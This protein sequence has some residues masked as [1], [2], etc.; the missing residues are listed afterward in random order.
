MGECNVDCIGWNYGNEGNVRQR[1]RKYYA[2]LRLERMVFISFVTNAF[3][4]FFVLF[5]LINC[6]YIYIFIFVKMFMG[7]LVWHW[8][9]GCGAFW[10]LEAPSDG[11]LLWLFL[12]RWFGSCPEFQS[13][14]ALEVDS[15]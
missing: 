11:D 3:K 4:F 15:R 6:F 13:A 12:C 9:F 14:I 8:Y 7:F 10:S 1:G 5:V 2:I